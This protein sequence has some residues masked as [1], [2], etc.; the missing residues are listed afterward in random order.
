MSIPVELAELESAAAQHDF[1]YLVTISD[2]NSAHV[3][4]VQPVVVD[5]A[6]TVSDLGRRSFAN[7]VAR[8]QVTLVWP[9]R[10]LGDYSLISDGTATPG[11]EAGSI[12]ITPLRAVKHRPAPAP[13]T[14][15][16]SEDCGSDC[17]ELP[18]GPPP[19]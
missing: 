6:V 8:P 3:V 10:T 15:E 1:A 12:A 16:D 7:S 17:V 19:A 2:D 14:D 5:T 9:P 18:V 11:P 4:A 13:S